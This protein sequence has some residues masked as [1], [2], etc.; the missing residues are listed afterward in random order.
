MTDE[1]KSKQQLIAELKTLRTRVAVL[2]ASG[3]VRPRPGESQTTNAHMDESA[4]TAPEELMWNVEDLNLPVFEGLSK[5]YED[6]RFLHFRSGPMHIAPPP[7]FLSRDVTETGSYD[8]TWMSMASFGK[9]LDA[10]PIP[11]LLVEGTGSIQFANTSFVRLS[12]DPAAVLSG[13]LLS[14][15]PDRHEAG[16]ARDLLQE[17]LTSRRP[18]T[19]EGVL[20]VAEKE[21]WSR[22]HLRPI[23]FGTERSILVLI[24]DL[25]PERRELK[26][27]EKYKKLVDIFPIGIGEFRFP[28]TVLCSAPGDEPLDLLISSTLTDGNVQFALLNGY[29]NVEELRGRLFGKIMPSSDQSLK[30]YR[31]WIES[32]FLVSRFETRG[33]TADGD[34]RY[35]ENTLV[36]NV[37]DGCL[38]QFWAMKQDI[39]ERKRVE[40]ELVEKIRTIDELYEHI[41]QSGKAKAIAEHTATVA[42]ELRQP[43]AIIGGFARRMAAAGAS[44]DAS[45]RGAPGEQVQIIVKE[46]QRLEKILDGL[47]DFTRHDTLALQ[48]VNPNDLIEYVVQINEAGL[49]KK[50]LI[51]QKELGQ[52]V[53]DIPLDPDRFQQVVRNLLANAIE[54]SDPGGIVR[55]ETGVSI[56]SEMAH[57]TGNLTDEGYFEIKVLNHGKRIA[58]EHLEKIFSPFFTTKGYSTG[59]GLTLAKKIVEDHN[60]SI[61]VQS[62]QDGTLLT[63]WLPL[64]SGSR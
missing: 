9:L 58:K 13:D 10:V 4:A 2:E 38:S 18:Q 40:Q 8:L 55:I 60:G 41:I 49:N 61:S 64:S 15:F 6:P 16:H 27:N 50:E 44:E 31:S 52:E 30:L 11:I 7:E 22:M 25:T 28:S 1:E 39:T 63:V 48:T 56:P 17:A 26:L 57:R 59:L 42:H 21:I 46:V 14:L 34:L 19:R 62:D 24:E 51:L 20:L 12:D 47:I 35:Y 36:G 45:S 54:A 33:K 23:R 32:G 29:N 43:L 37:Q 53:G 5:C 3:T